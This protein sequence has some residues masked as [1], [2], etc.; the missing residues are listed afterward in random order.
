MIDFFFVATE[1]CCLV[2]LRLN[3]MS[4]QTLSM[5]RQS[6][7]YS[8]LLA[9]LFV[10]TLNPSL[11]KTCLGLSHLFSIFCRDI[12]LLCRDR[13]ILLSSFY[14]R[15]IIFLCRDK[16]LCL[17]FFILSQHELLCRNILFVIFSTSAVTIFVFVAIKFT[18]A[19]CCVCRDIKLLYRDK[20]F[21]SPIPGSECYVAT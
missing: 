1:L 10:A 12:K 16:D 3:S 7:L 4:R 5:S 17:Q 20:V 8:L 6:L 13:N 21:L 15:N 9:E 11:R 19:S 18:S 2:L 14:Y